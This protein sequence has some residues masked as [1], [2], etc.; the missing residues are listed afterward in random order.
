MI[1][2]KQAHSLQKSGLLMS[3]KKDFGQMWFSPNGKL[4]I[5]ARLSENGELCGVAMEDTGWKP[6]SEMDNFVYRATLADMLTA[7]QSRARV[8]FWW[9]VE[10]VRDRDTPWSCAIHEGHEGAWNH[11]FGKTPEEACVIA[12]L[13]S[14]HK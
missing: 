7:L 13:T 4:Y 6:L 1:D 8:P 2:F 3:P 10:K 5:I 12:L 11:F 14:C 9:A